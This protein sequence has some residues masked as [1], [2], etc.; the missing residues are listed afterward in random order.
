MGKTKYRKVQFHYKNEDGFDC[1][2]EWR[3]RT[4]GANFSLVGQTFMRGNKITQGI[5]RLDGDFYGPHSVKEAIVKHLDEMMSPLS[6]IYSDLL[7]KNRKSKESVKVLAKK[8]D[9]TPLDLVMALNHIDFDLS[10]TEKI[11][12]NIY[13]KNW[14]KAAIVGALTVNGINPH[15]VVTVCLEMRKEKIV[16]KR[17]S[18]KFLDFLKI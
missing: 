4:Y 12:T 8:F 14:S 1:V 10:V 2:D 7:K 15:D 9:T 5:Y 16:D 17:L 13:S 3:Y 18:R 6:P 11:S